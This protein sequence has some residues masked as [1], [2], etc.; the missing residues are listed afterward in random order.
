MGV[1]GLDIGFRIEGF[2]F[3]VQGSMT[4]AISWIGSW[5]LGF[6]VWGLEFRMWGPNL[7]LEVR[8]WSL[9]FR[10]LGFG[11]LGFRVQGVGCRV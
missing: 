7:G 10:V 2:E 4:H 6:G 3:R 1:R 11:G 9:G 8:V 5:K